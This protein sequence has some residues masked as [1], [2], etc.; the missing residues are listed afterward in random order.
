[1]SWTEFIK[2]NTSVSNKTWTAR[3]RVDVSLNYKMTAGFVFTFREVTRDTL[4]LMSH[5]VVVS[6]AV[7]VTVLVLVHNVIFIK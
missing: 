7:T 2:R 6:S 3:S 5:I 1:M 4:K